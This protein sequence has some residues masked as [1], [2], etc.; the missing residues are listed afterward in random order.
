MI[1]FWDIPLLINH[2]LKGH[3]GLTWLRGSAP[4]SKWHLAHLDPPWSLP[5]SQATAARTP[6]WWRPRKPRHLEK[7]DGDGVA[8]WW[9]GE[10]VEWLSNDGNLWDVIYKFWYLMGY[11]SNDGIAIQWWLS[12]IYHHNDKCEII[13]NSVIWGHANDYH[14]IWE[15]FFIIFS[16]LVR[17]HGW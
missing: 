14:I 15:W 1:I 17:S 4:W 3:H 7:W 12:C 6:I 11:V 13:D 10:V 2:W 8:K 5:C 9:S 16:E